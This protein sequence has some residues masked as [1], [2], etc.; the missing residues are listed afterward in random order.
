M[1]R[2]YHVL[3]AADRDLDDQAGYLA[4]EASL[5]TALRFYDAASVTFG[6]IA[7][8]PGIGEQW[9]SAN[10][11]LA[12]LRVWRVEGFEKYLIF[13]RAADNDIEIIRIIH[14]ARDIDRVLQSGHL[15]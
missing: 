10:P 7:S 1:T 4:A 8:M 14:A 6:K 3:P 5:E 15:E 12:G 11:R 13:Y 9:P 2:H